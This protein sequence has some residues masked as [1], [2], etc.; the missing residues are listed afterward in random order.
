M[1]DRFA[2]AATILLAIALIDLGG[3]SL[4]AATIVHVGN[5][6]TT[7]DRWRT[8]DFLKP[9]DIDGDNVYGTDGYF[10]EFVAEAQPSYAE[11][12]LLAPFSQGSVEYAVFDD[13]ALTGPGPVPDLAGGNY[14]YD[15]AAGGAES[16]FFQIELLQSA[17]FR[18]IV[19]NDAGNQDLGGGG[20]ESPVQVR[21]RQ[22]VGGS[23][24]S[25]LIDVS[26]LLNNAIDY[27]MFDIAGIA[28]DTFV[29]SGVN[30]GEAGDNALVGI[31]FDGA[32]VP[33]PSTLALSAL[34][35]LC[36]ALFARHGATRVV[37]AARG[38]D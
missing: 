25:G 26:A 22:T 18:L 14:F 36:A 4:R 34:G 7:L 9:L 21:V 28:G 23:A 1:R 35:L 27:Y 17:A 38:G 6:T 8:T 29:V 33:E 15:D 13:P 3:L 11:N 24:D 37:P 19:V 30:D 12:T 2:A 20:N 31:L 5:D 32:A 16:D 10:A